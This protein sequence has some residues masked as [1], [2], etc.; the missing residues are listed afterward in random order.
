MKAIL[1]FLALALAS[2]GCNR[3]KYDK[4]GKPVTVGTFRV[5]TYPKGAKVWIKGELKAIH[6]PATLI[7]EQGE[8]QLKIQLE[9]AEPYETEITVEAGEALERTYRIPKPPPA[10]LSV[11]SDIEGADV[12][13][14]GYRRGATPLV[15]AVTRP[16]PIDITVTTW[17]GRARS[18]R[19]RLKLSEN[20]SVTV[21]FADTSSKAETPTAKASQ[22]ASPAPRG[23]LTL[24]LQPNGV[25][26]DAQSRLL[27]HTPL[28]KL[29]IEPGTHELLLRTYD[30]SKERKVELTVEPGKHAVYRFLLKQRDEVPEGRRVK[31]SSVTASADAGV[32]KG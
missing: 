18:V 13:I 2:S 14:N 29:P 21:T 30:G 5:R 8:Y 9:G 10:L 6:T 4:D 7:L 26:Y 12:R 11:Y 17:D 1:L 22:D 3:T 32:P 27:G 15:E 28:V 23:L 19:S 31:T 20:K 25:V 24:G 16:G